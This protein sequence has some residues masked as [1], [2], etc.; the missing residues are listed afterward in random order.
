MIKSPFSS[1][2]ESTQSKTLRNALKLRRLKIQH[3]KGSLSNLAGVLKYW[4][5]PSKV[6]STFHIRL[7]SYKLGSSRG[8]MSFMSDLLPGDNRPSP[9]Y[10]KIAGILH[11]QCIQKIVGILHHSKSL[12]IDG[13][14]FLLMVTCHWV[15]KLGG[16][17]HSRVE[18]FKSRNSTQI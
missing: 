1:H 8:R 2:Y 10:P 13:P 6:W 14:A 15:E 12:L 16:W 17:T 11:H 18:L 7:M 9:L 3:L 4:R 5:S